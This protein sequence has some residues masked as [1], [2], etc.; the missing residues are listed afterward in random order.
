LLAEENMNDDQKEILKISETWNKVR[1]MSPEE[2][3]KLEP[4]WKEAYDRYF[5]KYNKDMEFMTEISEKVKSM[6]EPV[7]IEKKTKGQRKRDAFAIVSA[8]E[9]FRAAQK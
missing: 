6:I 3:A 5:E 4:E 1:F 9:A 7:K 2:A 8:R